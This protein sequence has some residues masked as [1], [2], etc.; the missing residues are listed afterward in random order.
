MNTKARLLGVSCLFLLQG[1]VALAAEDESPHR[2]AALDV[3]QLEYASDPQIS[4]DGTRVV[5]VR[6]SM[7]IMKDRRRS[8][9]W[10]IDFDGTDN[11]KLTSGEGDESSPRWS[12][13]G[14]ILVY[15]SRTED[16]SQLYLRWM[17]TGQ[18]ARITQL[19]RPPDGLSWSPDG[20]WLAFSMLV[21]EEPTR[22]AEL[23]EKP[24]GAEWADPPRVIDRL[25]NRADGVGY[26]EPGYTHL[27]VLPVEGGT[28]R[29]VTSGSFH[30]R[31]RPAWTPDGKSFVFSA[32]RNPD[33][34]YEFRNSEIYS[35]SVEDNSIRALTDRN[36]PDRSPAVSPKGNR[37]AYVGYDDRIQTYQVT[38]LFVMNRDGS[39]KRAVTSKLDRDVSRP[40]WDSSGDGIFFQYHDR[41]NTKIG[42]ATLDGGVETVVEN[43]GGTSIGRPYPGGSFSVARNGRFAYTETRPEYPADI[44]VGQRGTRAVKRIT[45]LN[46]DLLGHKRLGAVQ[47]IVYPSS[48]DERQIQGWIVTPP[49][50]DPGR[51]YPLILEIHGGP[52]AN[53]GDRFS[54]EIQ[55]YAAAGYV[56]FYANPRGSTGYGREFGNLLHHNYPGQDYDDLMSGVDAVVAKGFVEESNLFVTGGSAG[57]VMT[58]W[59]VGKTSRF[60]AAVSAK[61]VINWYSKVLVADNYYAYHNYRYPGSP[62]ENPEAYLKFS[63]ISLVGNV[64]TPTLLMTG[65]ADLRTPL[66]E[67]EQFYHALKLRRV[68]TALVRIPGASHNIAAR[69]S[70]LIAK[71]AHVLAWFEA[72]REEGRVATHES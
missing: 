60:R 44:A 43:L 36:G 15:V 17:D 45:H 56:V 41:G 9:L 14:K 69:P 31:G 20:K 2:F 3:F 72:Y 10:I 53:Y 12:P 23:P 16:G 66:S 38:G 59:I 4:P 24:E 51:K 33:W 26:L 63:P 27:F 46:D 35:V 5:Y 19:L 8:S 67:A 71:V 62:W 21:P 64:S 22:L 54:A 37:I 18:T 50:F 55:L 68:D 25:R 42:Y 7:D 13:D 30:H 65:D 70:Q 11:R 29:Q 57:G 6:N 40:V 52:I 1:L 61:P 28:P 34:E 48:Y 49:D 58:A 39:A 32:N 47:E